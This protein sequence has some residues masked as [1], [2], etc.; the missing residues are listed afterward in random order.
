MLTFLRKI[1]RSLINTGST[2]KYLLYALGEVLL[3]MVGILL[4]LQ[5]NNWNEWRKDRIKEKEVLRDLQI[6]LESNVQ[7][8]KENIDLF[9]FRS[10][11]SRIVLNV[12]EKKLPY[13]DSL[14]THFF[15]AARGFGGA[16]ALSFVGFEG[17]RN[18][19]FDIITNKTL[20]NEILLLFESTYPKFISVDNELDRNDVFITE[21]LSDY[22]YP[23]MDV[24]VPFDYDELLTSRKTYSVFNQLDV[25]KRWMGN[26]YE[27]CLLE[28][29]RILQLI[30]DELEDNNTE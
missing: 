2:R 15:H 4:A 7:F 26:K 6:N 12:M 25:N 29:K 23:G 19:G 28:T 17:L 5:V 20:K 18:T 21:V 16:E 13:H 10:N 11:S 27:E 1:R 14:S 3:V 22:F 24:Y 30:K 8:L 9:A